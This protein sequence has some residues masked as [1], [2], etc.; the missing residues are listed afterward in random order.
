[1]SERRNRLP[2]HSNDKGVLIHSDRIGGEN[3]YFVS[4]VHIPIWYAYL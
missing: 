4:P 1:V 2:T 3:V